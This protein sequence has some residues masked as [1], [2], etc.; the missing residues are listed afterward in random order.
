MDLK[1]GF[2]DAERIKLGA[3]RSVV[4]VDSQRPDCRLRRTRMLGVLKLNSENRRIA[5]GLRRCR[6]SNGHAC[7]APPKRLGAHSMRAD[8]RP[9]PRQDAANRLAMRQPGRPG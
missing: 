3:Q 6:A 9:A 5:Q 4:G 8:A 2:V 7:T 1:C